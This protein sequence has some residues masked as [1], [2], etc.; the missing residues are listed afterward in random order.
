LSK[1]ADFTERDKEA[2]FPHLLALKRDKQ[3]KAEEEAY[4][5]SLFSHEN[6]HD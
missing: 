4:A 6:K 5:L 1:K 2:Y 3:S